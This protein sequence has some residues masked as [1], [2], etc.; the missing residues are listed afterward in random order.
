M[1]KLNLI[2]DTSW[3]NN[4]M[5]EAKFQTVIDKHR[6]HDLIEGWNSI[7]LGLDDPQDLYLD[8]SRFA[9]N[10]LLMGHMLVDG[11]KR[12]H[13]ALTLLINETIK[14]KDIL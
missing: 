2:I 7:V 14:F 4:T 10:R 9:Y 12:M 8:L 1:N 3:I 5:Q 6:I 13:R 11:N